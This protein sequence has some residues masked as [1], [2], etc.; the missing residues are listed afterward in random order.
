MPPSQQKTAALAL[1]AVGL[2]VTI[3]GPLIPGGERLERNSPTYTGHV[4]DLAGGGISPNGGNAAK[5]PLLAG[6]SAGEIWRYQ[7]GLWHH[8]PLDFGGHPITAIRGDPTKHPVGTAGGLYNPPPGIGFNER[9]GDLLQTPAG[10]VIGNE[11]GIHLPR[12]AGQL[13]LNPGM[14]VYRFASQN[15]DG[16]TI[17]HAGTM[18]AGILSTSLEAIASDWP[19]NNQGLPPETYVYS[20]AIT[21]GGKLIAGTKA[22]LYWQSR[23][24][25]TWQPL[26]AAPGD[27][28]AL[29]LYLAPVAEAETQ[30][31][32]LGGDGHLLRAELIETADALQVAT[33]AMAV[34]QAED[35]LPYGISWIRPTADGV[36]VSAGAVYQYGPVRLSGWYWISSAGIVLLLIAG[37]MLPSRDNTTLA[38]APASGG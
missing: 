35:P 10:L 13:L 22:G 30:Q 17:L 21:A 38:Q 32:W 20:F 4:T 16:Q 9:V 18:G 11:R 25:E 8:L 7:D 15:L 33:P 1:A 24:G 37:W 31:L 34:R 12:P 26:N 27:T 6:T 3:A 36:M 28:R 14:N 23:P 5:L 29:A 19:A 2:L